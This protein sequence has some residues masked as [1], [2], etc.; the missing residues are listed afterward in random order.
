[1]HACVGG[2]LRRRRSWY[3]HLFR[4]RRAAFYQSLKSKVGL[5]AA[6]AAALRT[7]R[8]VDPVTNFKCSATCRNGS[9]A[10]ECELEHETFYLRYRV[11][12]NYCNELQRR[13][14]PSDM[15]DTG[16]HHLVYEM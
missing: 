1:M 5:A 16:R 10:R 4:F 13:E 2:D 14:H 7:N 9:G 6:K 3:H 11:H 8:N 12:G 15:C